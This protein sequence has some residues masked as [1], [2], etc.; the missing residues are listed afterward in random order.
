MGEIGEQLLGATAELA[1]FAGDVYLEQ[2]REGAGGFGGPFVQLAG[3][4]QAVHA[5]DH[6]EQV[7]GVTALVGLKMADHVPAEVARALADFDPGFLNAVLPETRQA[8]IGGGP[9]GFR[10]PPLLTGCKLT[11]S[12]ARPARRKRPGCV[13]G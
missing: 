6:L 4:R 9:H 2:D 10:G 1:G 8:E 5:L 13:R 7:D 12:G 3:E 11:D